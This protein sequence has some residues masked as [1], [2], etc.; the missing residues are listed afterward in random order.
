MTFLQMLAFVGVYAS[1]HL[2][3]LF[4]NKLAKNEHG[5]DNHGATTTSTMTQF[6]EGAATADSGVPNGSP[7]SPTEAEENMIQEPEEHTVINDTTSTTKN[8]NVDDDDDD[9]NGVNGKC[10]ICQS[11][12]LFMVQVMLPVSFIICATYYG[13][14]KS[15]TSS[16]IRMAILSLMVGTVSTSWA[17]SLASIA[18]HCFGDGLRNIRNRRR[19]SDSP[20]ILFW[21]VLASMFLLAASWSLHYY[22]KLV[23]GNGRSQVIAWEAMDAVGDDPYSR[24][25]LSWYGCT[26]SIESNCTWLENSWDPDVDAW[27]DDFNKALTWF[28]DSP[29]GYNSAQNMSQ[30]CSKGGDMVLPIIAHNVAWNTCTCD[31]TW[32]TVYMFWDGRVA[33]ANRAGLWQ[34]KTPL[35][36][37]LSALW[38]AW[39]LSLNRRRNHQSGYSSTSD[40]WLT[41]SAGVV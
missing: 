36:F 33:L 21:Q 18:C 2:L 19:S 32:E 22:L 4:F 15:Y 9:G 25:R 16:P 31:A 41:P 12:L 14:V 28:E 20:R 5:D 24:I 40:Q 38:G 17:L 34:I 23:T 39:A 35:Y 3:V 8:D 11:V 30:F 26:A 10:I 29:D 6:V 1:I 7:S 27:G 37:G 13:M